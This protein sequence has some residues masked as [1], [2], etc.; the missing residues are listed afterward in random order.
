[1]FSLYNTLLLL[2]FFKGVVGGSLSWV[3]LGQLW[4][5]RNK[6]E[7]STGVTQHLQFITY[8]NLLLIQNSLLFM[9]VMP[10]LSPIVDACQVCM[11]CKYLYSM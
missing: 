2:R 11:Y 6:D 4:E 7:Y 10:W 8:G 9:C 3:L 5:R 1:M